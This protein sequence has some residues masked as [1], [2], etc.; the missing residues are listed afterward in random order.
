[1][2]IILATRIK[3]HHRYQCIVYACKINFKRL[4]EQTDRVSL[5][6]DRDHDKTVAKFN[7]CMTEFGLPSWDYWITNR[8]DYCINVRTSHVEEYIK[9]MQKGDV[10][11]YQRIAYNRDKHRSMHKPGS[12]YLVAQA[13]DGRKGKTG[14]Q[15]YNFYDKHAQKLYE[16]DVKGIE[17][18]DQELEQAKNILRLEVQCYKPKLEYTKRK[19]SLEDKRIETMLSDEYSKNIVGKAVKNVC[20]VGDYVTKNE[21]YKII[22][23]AKMQNATKDK[24]KLIIK[25]ISKQYQSIAKVREK[26]TE[27]TETMTR[28]NFNAYLKRLDQLGINAVTVNCTGMTDR[29]TSVYKL[30]EDT[31]DKE[32]YLDQIEDDV[33][34]FTDQDEEAI[35]KIMDGECF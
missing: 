17:V 27:E 2:G 33:P 26:L 22:D 35:E 24:L 14:S 10:P 1:M 28:N 30:F 3:K 9:L 31:V 18:T 19:Y 16:R 29:L 25:E 8:I 15:T 5:Y 11:Y 23:K 21:A 13:R 4:T 6:T 32:L 12:L 7:E 20:H 34:E